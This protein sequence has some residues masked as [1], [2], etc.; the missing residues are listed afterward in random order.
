MAFTSTTD[1]RRRR[2]IGWLVLLAL[3]SLS[4]LVGVAVLASLL[5]RDDTVGSPVPTKTPAL[6]AQPAQITGSDQSIQLLAPTHVVAGVGTDWPEGEL[7]GLSA[8]AAYTTASTIEL[9]VLRQRLDTMYA[10]TPGAEAEISQVLTDSARGRAHLGVPPGPAS[11]AADVDLTALATSY[12]ATSTDR[13]EGYVLVRRQLVTY[14]G[15]RL[16]SDI[17][18]VPFVVERVA[19]DWKLTA[20]GVSWTPPPVPTDGPATGEGW[21]ALLSTR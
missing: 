8:A 18:P 5:T 3:F 21:H 6:S 16:P 7:G 20:D 11:G 17:L 2:S 13:I 15:Q 4:A 9:D 10:D 12:R 19:G 14:T 1:R